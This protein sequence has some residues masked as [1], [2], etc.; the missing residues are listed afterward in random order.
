MDITKKIKDILAEY[1]KRVDNSSAPVNAAKKAMA[2]WEAAQEVA[3]AIGGTAA[4]IMLTDILDTEMTEAELAEVVTQLM[5]RN[6]ERAAEAARLAQVA[7]NAEAGIGLKPI[8]PEFDKVRNSDLIGLISAGESVETIRQK[9]INNSLNVVDEAIAE[10]TKLHANSGLKVTIT[11]KYDG[12]GLRNRKQ[13]CQWCLARSGTWTY[14]GAR[15]AEVF[16]RHVGCGCV[17]VY[18]TSKFR[19]I[20]VGRGSFRDL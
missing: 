19:Q 5:Q 15:E 12:V 7:T 3:K 2:K 16:A 11:R 14:E 10:N 8:V 20:Q 1:D 17:I 9:V 18:N 13:S 6:H 4:D